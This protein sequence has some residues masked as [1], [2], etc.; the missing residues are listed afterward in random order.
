LEVPSDALIQIH[1]LK[2]ES[3]D[4]RQAL[5]KTAIQAMREIQERGK[6]I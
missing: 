6:G 4:T 2:V 1:S 5:Q 3:F